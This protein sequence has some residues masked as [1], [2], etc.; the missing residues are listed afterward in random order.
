[1]DDDGGDVRVYVEPGASHYHA[2]EI[3][4][5][6]ISFTNTRV[7]PTQT[8]LAARPLMA[9]TK[10]E[11]QINAYGRTRGHRKAF[12]SIS[13]ARMARP[14]T[15]PGIRRVTPPPMAKYAPLTSS[16]LSQSTGT[17]K[18]LIGIK[19][20]VNGAP[21]STPG[22][23]LSIAIA[24]VSALRDSENAAVAVNGSGT[25]TTP[26]HRASPR[27][28][29]TTNGIPLSHPHARKQSA[30]LDGAFLATSH[31]HRVPPVTPSTSSYSSSL[32]PITESNPLDTTAPPAT[33]LRHTPDLSGSSTPYPD[34]PV[35]P[36]PPPLEN[37]TAHI[38]L[39]HAQVTGTLTLEPPSAA[40]AASWRVA[41]LGAGRR[42]V[43]GGRM[44]IGVTPRP[45]AASGVGAWLGMSD[46]RNGPS[47]RAAL[48]L[49]GL[50]SADS[51]TTSLASAPPDS[52]ASRPFK[53][54][55]H[56]ATSMASYIPGMSSISAL[57]SPFGDDT[58]VGAAGSRPT[59]RASGRG[60][61]MFGA[62]SIAV[63]NGS[64]AGPMDVLSSMGTV[65]QGVYPIL[66]SQP[67]VL[68]VDLSLQPGETRNYTYSISLPVALPP[69]FR[70]KY[71]RLTYYLVIGTTRP[72]SEADAGQLRR[73]IRVPIRMYNHVSIG[74]IPRPYDLMWP[75]A[76][77][78]EGPMLVG[79]VED[80][81]ISPVDSGKARP[82]TNQ[83]SADKNKLTR[84]GLE[85]YARKLLIESNPNALAAELSKMRVSP[86][87]T[88]ND[89]DESANMS[90][91]DAVEVVTRHSKKVSYD[92]A[93]DGKTFA[94]ITFVKASYR[95]GETVLG[96][97]EF[98]TPNMDG[99]VLKYSATL[100]STES[101]PLHTPAP[102]TK[103]HAEHH[104]A[105]A[106]GTQ[107]AAFSLDIPSD[108]TPTFVL[109]AGEAA[110]KGIEGG[111]QWRVRMALV[112]CM[113][114]TAQARYLESD[115]P[116]N[117]W[118]K[119]WRA[120][121]EAAPMG[122]V[123]SKAPPTT[124]EGWGAFFR[125][126]T[127]DEEPASQE[128]NEGWARLRPETVECELPIAVFP[129]STAYQP[130]GFDTWA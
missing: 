4:T 81:K 55:H 115:G 36:T 77:R 93:K 26:T 106:S 78:R 13:E 92:I 80:S 57:L 103:K 124:G 111:L 84:L 44:G 34:S 76:R 107:R 128:A 72:D 50:A 82:A 46:S 94:V 113:S 16:S 58:A 21:R 37:N 38:L 112:V 75:L 61:E 86:V 51:S 19:K 98:N 99:Q 114:P 117:D 48:G 28:I 60:S 85:S 130:S 95:L 108:G 109:R 68:A 53:K 24:P 64:G 63:P 43:G 59:S 65:E 11:D 6:T 120:T 22:R 70:G 52:P 121:G 41:E 73:V 30:A 29:R 104:V 3:A 122:P 129:G 69:S 119:A 97:I 54:G 40:L 49:G 67:A 123:D 14:P 17:R 23:P 96:A 39:A 20:P 9:R 87:G 56:R 42:V 83:P 118:G 10:S 91:R 12:S 33:S 90:C 110:G 100:E 74:Q 126:W 88:R 2:G 125:G 18:G 105:Y 15:S 116:G 1:M 45:R 102:Q 127:G 89:D 32:A 7:I 8:P 66:E 5:F 31:L 101:F 71:F 27:R 47:V 25:P 62:G 79:S 35:T